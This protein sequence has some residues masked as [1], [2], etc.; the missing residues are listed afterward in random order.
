MKIFQNRLFGFVLA[1]V[2]GWGTAFLAPT[3]SLAATMTATTNNLVSVEFTVPIQSPDD[4]SIIFGLWTYSTSATISGIASLYDGTTL[5]GQVET[6]TIGARF[7]DPSSVYSGTA[8][9]VDIDYSSVSDGSIT[10]LFTFLFTQ[11][12][13]AFATFDLNDFYVHTYTN[14]GNL[15][16]ND[17]SVT[18]VTLSTISTVPLPPSAILFGTALLGIAGL[19]RRKRKIS[20]QGDLMA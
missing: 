9:A 16:T 17:G 3:D 7:T 19:R 1:T 18:N 8:N 20:S 5:L 2:V 4:S 14:A 15:P 12:G 11:P 13:S 6:T 10:G